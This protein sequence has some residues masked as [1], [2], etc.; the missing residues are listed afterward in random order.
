M[1]APNL[2]R[3]ST[4]IKFCGLCRAA[5]VEQAV[6][7]GVDMIGLV[8]APRS[9][10]RLDLASAQ[11][12]RGLIP[13]SI[14]V[15]ALV[16][17][18]PANEVGAIIEA[19]RPDYLQFHGQETDAFCA[20]FDVPF[21]K[22]IALG[23]IDASVGI[24]T[25]AKAWPTAERLLFDGH[26]AGEMG[27]AGKT[28]DWTRLSGL[29]GKP[30]LLAGGLHPDNVARAIRTAH[31]WGV[32]VSSGIESAPGLKD[33]GRMRAFVEAVRAADLQGS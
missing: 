22:A 26:G 21:I 24:E 32:D 27:G 28:F 9:A 5:D 31:P 7:L 33:G 14:E 18:N 13:G 19:V 6:A 12:L 17:D 30:F 15:V 20:G 2:P 25:L 11:A 1:P 29:V 8:F 3:S 16:M 4:R 23:G 10:R